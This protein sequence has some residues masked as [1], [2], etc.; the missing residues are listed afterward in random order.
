MPKL[1][2]NIDGTE[3]VKKLVRLGYQPVRQTG[4]HIRLTYSSGNKEHHITIPA[5]SPLKI[6]TLNAILDN[7]AAFLSIEKGELIKGLF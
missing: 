5:H 4:S 6:G 7:V 1:P 2:R 3:L